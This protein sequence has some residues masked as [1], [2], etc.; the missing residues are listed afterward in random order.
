VRGGG[1]VV[2][3]NEGQVPGPGPRPRALGGYRSSGGPGCDKARAR[4]SRPSDTCPRRSQKR[5]KR[6]RQTKRLV[7]T[8]V[9][10]EVAVENVVQ[11]GAQIVVLGFQ[12]I[13]PPF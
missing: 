9:A 7:A 6:A 3:L 4:R 11:N 1:G 10:V 13:Q 8:E 2:I 5:H 12:T